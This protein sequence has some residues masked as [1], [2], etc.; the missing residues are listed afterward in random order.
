MF[1]V[2]Q[3]PRETPDSAKRELMLPCTGADRR[4]ATPHC[5]DDGAGWNEIDA[6]GV[7]PCVR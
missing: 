5:I 2:R 7:I 4:S 1:H 3:S 6:T